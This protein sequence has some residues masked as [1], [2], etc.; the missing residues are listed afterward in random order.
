[1][2]VNLSE[3][4]DFIK[5]CAKGDEKIVKELLATDSEL[6]GKVTSNGSTPLMVAVSKGL[7]EIVE[8]LL[9]NKA[10]INALS[11]EGETALWLATYHK[12][13]ELAE[14]LLEAGAKNLD[15]TPTEGVYR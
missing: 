15:V 8:L 12:K 11:S 2:C 3:E 4:S 9:R 14:K 10:D 6:I 5:A 13:W 7:S 1:M